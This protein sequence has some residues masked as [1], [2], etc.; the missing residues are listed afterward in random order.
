MTRW[1]RPLHWNEATLAA[2]VLL[3]W[4]WGQRL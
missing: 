2:V 3:V 4:L 1:Q